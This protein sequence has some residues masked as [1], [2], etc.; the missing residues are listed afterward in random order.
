[1]REFMN[2]IFLV[3]GFFLLIKGADW[4]VSGA[5][6][7]ARLLRIPSVMI[8]LTVVAMGTSAPELSVSIAGALGGQ[9]GISVGNVVGSNLFNL[10]CVGGISAMIRS[11]MIDGVLLKRDIPISLIAAV[12]FFISAANGYI[13]RWEGT[14]FLILFTAFLGFM[15]KDAFHFRASSGPKSEMQ[16][17]IKPWKAV[18]FVLF[19][20]LG[21]IWG[22]NLVVDS[23]TAIALQFGLS[24]S[25]IGLTIVAL[26]TSLPEFVTSLVAA[27]K[28]ENDI[29]MG[30]IIGSNIFNLGLVLGTA[31]VIRPMD[32]ER[33]VTVDGI[34]LCI[35]TLVLLFFILRDKKLGRGRGTILFLLYLPYLLY[36]ILRG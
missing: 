33:A 35:V 32:V 19:G 13:S 24:E 14:L 23:A 3:I 34:F 36:I 31:A 11:I 8:G 29:A 18:S 28:G 7:I 12:L 25:L 4:F 15:L 9:S 10:L 1:M 30:N 17:A 26:G 16:E 22:G 5:S 2:Y 6:G 21:V 20:L 27:K